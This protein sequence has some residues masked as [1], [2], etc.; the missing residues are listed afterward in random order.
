LRFERALGLVDFVFRAE[1]ETPELAAGLR[2]ESWTPFS[3]A[4]CLRHAAEAEMQPATR[5][6]VK[7]NPVDPVA[8]WAASNAAGRFACDCRCS[9]IRRSNHWRFAVD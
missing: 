4:A 1:E 2:G 8:R 5:V 6:Q 9:M 7:P 3:S